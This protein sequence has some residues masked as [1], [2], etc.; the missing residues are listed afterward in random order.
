MR[1]IDL[2]TGYMQ[3]NMIGGFPVIINQ[4]TLKI[5]D[6]KNK[7]VYKKTLSKSDYAPTIHIQ[8]DKIIL[9]Y[10]SMSSCLDL[11]GDK[12]I[13][14][15]NIGDYGDSVKFI[16]NKMILFGRKESNVAK[17]E[18]KLSN[19]P[20]FNQDKELTKEL[21]GKMNR[22]IDSSSYIK[23]LACIDI[24]NGKLLWEEEFT[25]YPSIIF[26]DDRIVSI[27]NT[28]NSALRMIQA[29]NGG[30]DVK[31]NVTIRQYKQSTGKMMY[32]TANEDVDLY[33]EAKVF[34]DIL[35]LRTS[36]GIN[37]ID[38]K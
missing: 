10:D 33:T 28:G 18:V 23:I 31:G 38:L 15:K 3:T 17:E 37:G 26:S 12:V 21:E 16:G 8:N 34:G 30:G 36:N 32:Q 27:Y 2:G 25:H 9:V 11:N 29:I 35:F 19:L 22:D 20:G 4:Q 14:K 6:L 13:W 24:S 5:I 1:K 7:K